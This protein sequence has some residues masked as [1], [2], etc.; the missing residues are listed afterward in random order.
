MAAAGYRVAFHVEPAYAPLVR[1]RALAGLAR[2]T[3][4]AEKVR[5]PVELGIVVAGDRTLR[6][7]NRRYRRRDAPTDVLSFALE[8]D[9]G[10]VIPPGRA[11]QLGEIVISYQ[12]AA[13]QA[14]AAGHT[15]H[16]ELA[17]LLVHGLLHLIGYDHERPRQ[18]KLMRARE[19]ALLDRAA[20]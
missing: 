2:R 20:H 9:G 18:A 11:R 16:D 15:V 7:L 14:R 19:E 3:L 10:F 8:A 4:A 13:R 5:G 17:H 6:A 1:R 12:T